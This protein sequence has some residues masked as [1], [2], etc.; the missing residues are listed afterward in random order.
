MKSDHKITS[1]DHRLAMVKLA[2]NANP[3]F[4]VSG[5]EL[6]RS[7]PTY[8]V[9]TLEQL[10]KELGY[11]ASMYLLVGWDSLLDMPK[12][13]APLRISKM[14]TIV[15]FPRPGYEKPDITSLEADIPGLSERLVMLDEP[16]IG[17]SST[18]I[19]R[20]IASGESIRYMVPE[21]VRQY[22]A[23]N[24]LYGSL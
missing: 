11:A 22:I 13:K 17:I 10:W 19:R 18:A 2:I 24:R 23:D 21:T 4:H 7:G 12:W 20:K 16:F 9:D 8:T 14:A 15:T 6:E 5:I 3:S 1:T